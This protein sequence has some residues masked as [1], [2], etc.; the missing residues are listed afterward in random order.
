MYWDDAIKPLTA[1]FSDALR[2]A[3]VE[4][5]KAAAAAKEHTSSNSSIKFSSFF[6]AEYKSED[7][8]AVSDYF[9]RFDWALQ[10]SQILTIGFH[11]FVRVHI[12]TELNRTSKAKKSR[13]TDI[14]RNQELGC[15]SLRSKE[16][17]YAE[18]IKFRNIFQD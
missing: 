2:N 4:A 12:T 6:M 1:L 17:Q 14:V 11:N 9:Q 16:K 10:L 8:T 18:S 13:G 7:K 15:L 5:T 3:V